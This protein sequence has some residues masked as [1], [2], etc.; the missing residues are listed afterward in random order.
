MF[1]VLLADPLDEVGINILE[2]ECEVTK[3]FDI[4]KQ[5]LLEIINDYDAVLVRVNT[6]IDKEV[7]DRA[8]KL[9]VIGMPGAGLNH[10]DTVYAAQKGIKVKNVPGGNTDSVAELTFA[11]IL[12][13]YRN[14][15][16][17]C[18]KVRNELC[19]NKYLF[20]G[21]ELSEKIIGILGIGKIGLRVAEIARAFKIQITAYDP[22]VT[23]DKLPQDIRLLSLSELLS[24]ADIITIH[25][26][27][28]KETYHLISFDQINMMKKGTC[29]VNMSRGGIV[30]EEAA[31]EGLLSGRLGGMGSDVIEDEPS[32]EKPVKYTQ[33]FK[34]D[35]FLITP[36]LGA[37]TM[38][39]QNRVAEIIAYK[40]LEGLKEN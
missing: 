20:M 34:L 1:K 33:L 5:G 27:L 36:H 10:I 15:V 22:Y 39:A 17:S 9:K 24:T 21:H 40:M 16:S 23:Q 31:Y 8:N 28:N 13:L 2:A 29:I 11:H 3:R 35:N 25:I 7:I 6:P 37:W 19:W 12:A 4:N 30:N 26:P 14:V 18:N 32:P 38:E